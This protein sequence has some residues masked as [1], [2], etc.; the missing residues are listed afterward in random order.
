MK[1]SELEELFIAYDKA[2]H[3]PLRIFGNDTSYLKDLW[4]I[5]E[6]EANTAIV[7]MVNFCNTYGIRYDGIL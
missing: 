2:K 4:D 6:D 3:S 5:E 7:D 1:F